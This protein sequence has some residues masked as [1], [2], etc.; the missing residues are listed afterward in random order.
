MHGNMHG[1]ASSVMNGSWCYTGMN[2]MNEAIDDRDWSF[3][4]SRKWSAVESVEE[5]IIAPSISVRLK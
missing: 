1:S 2:S 4:T 3:A 5:I